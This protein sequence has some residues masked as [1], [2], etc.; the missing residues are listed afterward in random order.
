MPRNP[1]IR[2]LSLPEAVIL[3]FAVCFVV[4]WLQ[5]EHAR[6]TDPIRDHIAEHR[7]ELRAIGRALNAYRADHG[8]WPPKQP[9]FPL[10]RTPLRFAGR[11]GPEL[12]TWR[13]GSLTTP[14]AWLDRHTT[15]PFAGDFGALPPAWA[16][17]RPE[18]PNG[19]GWLLWTMGPDQNYNIREPGRI[20]DDPVSGTLEL[21]ALTYDPTNGIMSWGDIVVRHQPQAPPPPAEP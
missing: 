6:R 20:L 9:L 12:T 5:F 10:S 17:A 14:V 8:A 11:F 2:P 19:P 15:D 7:D 4:A 16:P 13:G 21:L 18:S 3:V 1:R